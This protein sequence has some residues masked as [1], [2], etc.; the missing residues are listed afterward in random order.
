MG[1]FFRSKNVQQDAD[2][3]LAIAKELSSRDTPPEQSDRIVVEHPEPVASV[4]I[5]LKADESVFVNIYEHDLMTFGV[6]HQDVSLL[7]FLHQ[8][9][10]WHCVE[11]E[12]RYMPLNEKWAWLTQTHAFSTQSVDHEAFR[13]WDRFLFFLRDE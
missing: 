10:T 2:N 7:H 8:D 9:V 6:Q 1:F 11:R 13:R 5:G 12:R 4:N 3:S